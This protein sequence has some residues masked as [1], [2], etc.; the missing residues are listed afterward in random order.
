MIDIAG[1]QIIPAVVKYTTELAKSLSSVRDACP[2]ADV[3]VQNELL[4][5]TSD[6]L[7]D[8]KLALSKLQDETAKAADVPGNK[9][10][11]YAY[12][13]HVTTAMKELRDPADKLE[14]LVDKELWPFPS[15]GDLIFEV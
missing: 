1:K 5:E 2:E 7:A 12:L 6:L 9:E 14:M 13:N 3:S 11:A 15:Y 4:L 8:M 10:R